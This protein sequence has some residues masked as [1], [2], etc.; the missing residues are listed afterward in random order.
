MKKNKLSAIINMTED[1]SKLAPLT[2]SR[3]IGA[4]PFACRYRLLDFTLSSLS[5]ADIRSAAIFINETGRSV[6]D[7]IR[8]GQA[9]DLDTNSGGIFTYSQMKHKK[10]LY[11]AASR[12]GDFYE[13]H[14]IFIERANSEYVF[15][16]GSKIL[17]S[18]NLLAVMDA[19]EEG[20][21][22]VMRLYAKKEKS[23]V[24]Y[25]PEENLLTIDDKGYVTDLAK[26]GVTPI[27]GD[28]VNFDMN[29][30]IMPSNILLEIIDKANAENLNDNL[31]QIIEKYLLDY[32]VQGYEYKGFV[33]NIDSVK[34][35]YDTSLS[36]LEGE[37]FTSLFHT[38]LP[39]ITRTHNGAPSYY[40]AQAKVHNAQIATHTN[41]RGKISHSQI[42][43][44]VQIHEG[45]EVENSILFQ[46]CVVE[47]GARVK[48]AIL[49]KR[50]YVEAG[51]VLEGSPEEPLVV[52]KN[53]RIKA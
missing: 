28:E 29:M 23:F 8:S 9:W 21:A 40:G 22:E 15:I 42:S 44:K 30:T 49:D 39:I 34:A 7:H 32:T 47:E 41:I 5:H 11:E 43:R 10:A 38:E 37:A 3:P 51:A 2:D 1:D 6:Y 17:A 26:K 48:N 13:D 18:V 46:G 24:E 19:F 53:T 4:L 35:Y 14:K 52:A 12:I 31:D 45:A 16:S 25:H 33:S 20:T 50:V 27:E 36:M